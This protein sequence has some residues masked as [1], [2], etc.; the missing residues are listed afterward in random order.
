V[1]KGNFTKAATLALSQLGRSNLLTIWAVLA[2][3]LV[4]AVAW[5]VGPVVRWSVRL[6]RNKGTT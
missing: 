3:A 2:L 6:A 5:L 1:W 4:G